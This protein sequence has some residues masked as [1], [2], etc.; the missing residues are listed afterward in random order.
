MKGTQPIY[1]HAIIDAPGKEKEKQDLLN[2]K[3]VDL[4]DVDLTEDKY[5]DISVTCIAKGDDEEK[6]LSGV[7]PVRIY[8]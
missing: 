5:V 2:K 7:P 3:M 4:L 8:F 1:L 6:M